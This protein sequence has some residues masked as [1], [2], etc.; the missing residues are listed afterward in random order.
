MK[1]YRWRQKKNLKKPTLYL[2]NAGPPDRVSV[3]STTCGGCHPKGLIVASDKTN[4]NNRNISF[5][6]PVL[7]LLF[8]RQEKNQL[9]LYFFPTS[10]P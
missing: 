7:I 6:V 8:V 9:K 2:V 5:N 10:S 3:L 4:N 1:T